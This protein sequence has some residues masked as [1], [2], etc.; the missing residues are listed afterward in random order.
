M[1]K[2]EAYYK[3]LVEQSYFQKM[4]K[5]QPKQNFIIELENALYEYEDKLLTLDISII[6]SLKQKYNIKPKDFTYER[7]FLL[8]RFISHCLWD[9]HLSDEEKKQLSYLAKLLDISEEYLNNKITE[10]GK[11]IYKK[12]VQLVISDDKIEDSE[13]KELDSLEKEFNISESDSTE[14]LSNEVSSKIQ[15][16]VNSLLE[17]RRIS[18]E[19]ENKL[20]E[21]ISGMHVSASFS[22]DGISRFRKY[23]DIENAELIPLDSPINLQKSENLYF[24]ANIEWF[25]ERTRT[26][27]VSYGGI[28]TKF[29]ICKGVYLRG[30]S[31][32]PMRNTEEY[33]K[34]IDNGDIYFTNKRIIF[35]GQHGNKQI[36]YSKILAFTPFADGIEIDKDT[37][38]KPFFK[39][40]DSELMGIYLAR[41]LKD[42]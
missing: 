12:K 23:W 29:K 9:G 10:E 21:M 36:P 4:F 25:E 8:N 14:I 6:T 31:I 13:T 30:G 1:S 24:S 22:G 20:N 34:L 7:E 17:K 18:P 37:G 26:T 32:A 41:L 5:K 15:S 40:E 33:L 38:K 11:A 42:F 16:Y 28:S 19:E 27:T 35:M 2:S 3:E 39:Y